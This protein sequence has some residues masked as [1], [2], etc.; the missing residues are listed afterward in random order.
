[1]FSAEKLLHCIHH[2][3]VILGMFV[4]KLFHIYHSHIADMS[5]IA[6]LSSSDNLNH[7]CLFQCQPRV[8]FLKQISHWMICIVISNPNIILP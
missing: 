8:S 2:I 7:L 3:A 4:L 5:N 1:M 6:S